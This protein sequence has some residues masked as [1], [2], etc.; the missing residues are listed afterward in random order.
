MPATLEVTTTRRTFSAAAASTTTRGARAFML[1]TSSAGRAAT[2]P[3][4]WKTVVQ[5]RKARRSAARS[6]TSARTGSASVPASRAS[7]LSSR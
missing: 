7:R 2:R 1:Q 6:S 5:P 3:A 4:Q